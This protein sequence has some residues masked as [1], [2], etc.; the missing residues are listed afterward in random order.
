MDVDPS[1]LDPELQIAKYAALASAALGL[2]GLC[3]SVVP[4]CGGLVSVLGIVLGWVSLRS[5]R[6]TLAM[7]GIGISILSLLIAL[8]Y[9]VILTFNQ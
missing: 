6:S 7:V 8:V 9:T 5:E 2:I 3:G 4:I 1:S